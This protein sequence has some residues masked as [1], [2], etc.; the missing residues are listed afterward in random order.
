MP[1]PFPGDLSPTQSAEN[2]ASAARSC[3]SPGSHEGSPHPRG[4]LPASGN[5]E[6]SRGRA[7]RTPPAPGGAAATRTLPPAPRARGDPRRGRPSPSRAR[8]G[9]PGPGR[10][11]DRG[12]GGS[13]RGPPG[14]RAAA[15]TERGGG[16]SAASTRAPV[17][18]AA[19]ETPAPGPGPRGRPHCS[20]RGARP[21]RPRQPQPA[22]RRE[23]RGRWRARALTFG[24]EH[25][26]KG[27]VPCC[28]H[29]E[30]RPW[31]MPGGGGRGDWGAARRVRLRPA[32]SAP[33]RGGRG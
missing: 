31:A 3:P 30:A 16:R 33:R 13:R 9:D 25:E 8:V 7:P 15:G 2:S 21:A 26:V 18:A 32:G 22:R 11:P 14:P 19:R 17:Q 10:R 23:R 4:N 28:C 27:A 1:R 6:R 24:A 5:G 29:S 20:A 12:R